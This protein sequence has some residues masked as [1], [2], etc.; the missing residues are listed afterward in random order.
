MTTVFLRLQKVEFCNMNTAIEKAGK[1]C[2]KNSAER[3]LDK[4]PEM[5]PWSFIL[6][7]LSLSGKP[8]FYHLMDEEL[9]SS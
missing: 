5:S 2:M 3:R 6:V 9:G 1:I 7:N 4:E 8:K